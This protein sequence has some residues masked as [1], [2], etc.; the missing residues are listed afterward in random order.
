MGQLPPSKRQKLGSDGAELD[1]GPENEHDATQDA[2][3]NSE[4]NQKK[5]RGK[6]T[7]PRPE[8]PFVVLLTATSDGSHVVAVTGQDKTLWVFEHDGKGSLEQ[9][10][11]RYE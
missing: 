6:W 10:S 4:K 9:V 2:P 1:A 8:A 5:G 11:Q 7:Q 3:A